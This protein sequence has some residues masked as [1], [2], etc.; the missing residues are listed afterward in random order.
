M[1]AKG[2][3]F[4]WIYNKKRWCWASIDTPQLVFQKRKIQKSETIQR[5]WTCRFNQ[6]LKFTRYQNKHF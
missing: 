5:T 1:N 3:M 4:V 2:F 6:E